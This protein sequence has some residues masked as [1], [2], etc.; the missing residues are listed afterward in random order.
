MSRFDH[1]P[2]ITPRGP[3]ADLTPLYNAHRVFVA[4]TRYA[5]GAPYKVLEAAARGVPIVATEILRAELNWTAGQE[6][7]AADRDDSVG[8]ANHIMAL[9][10]DE[11]LW[12]T[13]RD[14]TLHRLRQENGREEFTRALKAALT[15]PATPGLMLK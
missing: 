9:Y 7:L 6:I 10:R 13:I 2:R 1:H 8:F 11:A 4:P 12:R 15:Q 5:A 3:V 14:G